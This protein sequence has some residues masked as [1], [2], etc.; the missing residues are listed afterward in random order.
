MLYI[1]SSAFT[2]FYLQC[3]KDVDY[4]NEL[5]LLVVTTVIDTRD[6]AMHTASVGLYDN[7]TGALAKQIPL[8]EGWDEV[9]GNV[10]LFDLL[11]QN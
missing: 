6:D 5:D 4:E 7:K 11:L 2:L 8:E 9:S 3:I 1:I 10:R